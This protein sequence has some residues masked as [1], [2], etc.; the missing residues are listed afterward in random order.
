MRTLA[1]PPPPWRSRCTSRP[2]H[3]I[4]PM[5]HTCNQGAEILGAVPGRRLIQAVQPVEVRPP[6]AGHVDIKRRRAIPAALILRFRVIQR[7][8]PQM[9]PM[10]ACM[11]RGI[12]SP[13]FSV[14]AP[15]IA[16]PRRAPCKLDHRGG[17]A[18]NCL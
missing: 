3:Q 5:R 16:R 15:R 2:I 11:E 10:P 14:K 4:D 6:E 18:E 12:E 17:G 8:C 7:P 13:E 9:I 1:T